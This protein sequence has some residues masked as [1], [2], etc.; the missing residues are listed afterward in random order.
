MTNEG[1]MKRVVNGVEH[2]LLY[3][4]FTG[5]CKCSCGRWYMQN[6]ILVSQRKKENAFLVH[7]EIE[8]TAKRETSV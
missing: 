6:L 3:D 2:T 5:D 1:R 4:G 8:Q 7:I